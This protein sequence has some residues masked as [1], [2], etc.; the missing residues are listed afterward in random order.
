[1]VKKD[2]PAVIIRTDYD[3]ET[4]NYKITGGKFL[5]KDEAYKFRAYCIEKGY[6]DSWVIVVPK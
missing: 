4:Q 5:T 1:M 6:K 3:G 2:F